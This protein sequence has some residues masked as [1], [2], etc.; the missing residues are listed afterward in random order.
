MFICG[1]FILEE[2]KN[3]KNVRFNDDAKPVKFNL[4]FILFI[5]VNSSQN[6]VHSVI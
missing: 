3:K 2:S 1:I 6:D 5:V 4:D